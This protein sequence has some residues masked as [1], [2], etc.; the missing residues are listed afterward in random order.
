[1][2]SDEPTP[3]QPGTPSADALQLHHHTSQRN[4][5]IDSISS[6]VL[7]EGKRVRHELLYGVVNDRKTREFHHD[8]VSFKTLR[9]TK[10]QPWKLDPKS[11][12]TLSEDK[13]GE[14]SK[15]LAFLQACRSRRGHFVIEGDFSLA[16]EQ[17]AELGEQ[18][19]HLNVDA[20]LDLL[21]QLFAELIDTEP[22]R[23]VTA[24]EH[25]SA[26]E[27]ETST[28][29]Y[30][31]AACRKALKEFRRLLKDP[32]ANPKAFKDLLAAHPWFWGEDAADY[33]ALDRILP[34]LA[35]LGMLRQGL[36]ES[37]EFLVIHSP[38]QSEHALFSFDP[39]H[40][41]WFPGPDLNRL[42]GQTQ[43]WLDQLDTAYAEL[44]PAGQNVRARL[45][46]G[47]THG[48]TGVEHAILNLNRHLKRIQIQSFDQLDQQAFR[49]LS[50]L[51][52]NLSQSAK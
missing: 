16:Q 21:L 18:L 40:Q 51:Q 23:L 13:D 4:P 36:D 43:T 38:L 15:A 42:L 27:L 2:P 33:L 7:Y 34:E 9:K 22:R 12:F 20:K 30:R 19:S 35:R 26:T 48:E 49:I 39:A 31:V 10:I 37:L 50:G 25:L 41:S 28:R 45:L 29:V 3:I 52:N 6:T 47:H 46:I 32:D 14:L 24:L 1:M 8:Y 5:D 11:S 44:L 17:A